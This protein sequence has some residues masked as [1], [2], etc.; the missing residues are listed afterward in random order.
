MAYF[1]ESSFD[2]AVLRPL[3]KEIFGNR[4]NWQNFLLILEAKRFKVWAS[5]I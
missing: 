4:K 1:T 5:K 2:N 3:I